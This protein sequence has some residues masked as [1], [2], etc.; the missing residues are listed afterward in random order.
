MKRALIVD[1]SKSARAFL[2]RIL[3]KYEIG[4]DTAE[5]A[6]QAIEYLAGERPDVIF[7]DHLMP[8]MDGFQAVQIIKNNPRTATIPIMMY[9]SQEGELYVGQA[10]ALGAIGVLPKQIQPTDVSKVLY[11]LKLI[12]DRRSDE[13]RSFEAVLPGES[14]A[15]PDATATRAVHDPAPPAAPPADTADLRT[16]IEAIVR[17]QAAASRRSIAAHFDE[18]AARL[19][20]EMRRAVEEAMPPAAPSQ[21]KRAPR[22]WGWALA[23]LMLV[24]AGVLG[25]LW[26]RAV[27]TG[28]LLAT[29]LAASRAHGTSLE[30]RV[31]T[32]EAA[33]AA[34]AE[35]IASGVL[36][37]GTL[38]G[39]GLLA[40]ALVPY[41][42][43]PLS[44][45]RLVVVRDALA[46]LAAEGF[47]GEVD[48]TTFP[49]RFCLIGN[50][51]EGYS[52]APD[53]TLVS[54]CDLIGNPAFDG[55]RP[56]QR[57]SLAFAN[58]VAESRRESGG[59]IDVRVMTGSADDTA[60]AY[61]AISGGLTA[62]DWNRAGNANNR[63][64]LRARPAP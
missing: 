7:M 56:A 45:D 3:S 24:A 18:Q 15:P 27:G 9:T 60:L 62:A 44:N 48:V 41:G 12:P 14:P 1:D 23:A 51:T 5:S 21:A 53:D 29:D 8:G 59:A 54:R 4:V 10:R 26:W 64:E 43:V 36:G 19:I 39:E 17:E 52:L 40:R 38:A 28:R 16:M 30:K 13:Q 63:V 25:A 20:Q 11:Q 31:A 34:R 49:G 32:L 46:K 50:A 42:A 22:P 35:E 2:A 58:L 6:E 47:R 55:T 37:A 61:P 33:E 57:E